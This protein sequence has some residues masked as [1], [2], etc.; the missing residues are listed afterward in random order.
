MVWRPIIGVSAAHRG[1]RCCGGGRRRRGSA[2]RRFAR[3]GRG[4][5]GAGADRFLDEF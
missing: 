1:G 3:R 5:S 2:R 4:R